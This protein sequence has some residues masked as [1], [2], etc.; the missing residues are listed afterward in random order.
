MIPLRILGYI[1][2]RISQM[3]EVTLDTNSYTDPLLQKEVPKLQKQIR[4]NIGKVHQKLYHPP[5]Y[6]PPKLPKLSS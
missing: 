2:P 4:E 3:L 6:I 1:V 5:P